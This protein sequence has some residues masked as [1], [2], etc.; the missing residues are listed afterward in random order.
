MDRDEPLTICESCQHALGQDDSGCAWDDKWLCRNCFASKFSAY[1]G[2]LALNPEES[3]RFGF[4]EALLRGIRS[5]L[6][7]NTL[8]AGMLFVLFLLLRFAF[9][10]AQ[11][12]AGKQFAAADLL[13]W[14]AFFGF[15]WAFTGIIVIP[16]VVGSSLTSRTRKIHI[17]DGQLVEST[18]FRTVKLSMAECVWYELPSGFEGARGLFWRRQLIGVYHRQNPQQT[19]VCGFTDRSRRLWSGYFARTLHSPV[20]GIRKMRVLIGCLRG[21]G[22]GGAA[23]VA[24]G[25][26]ISFATGDPQWI[27]ACAS[28]GFLDGIIW[29]FCDALFKTATAP[30]LETPYEINQAVMSVSIIGTAALL[31]FKIGLL[32]GIPGAIACAI[33]NGVVGIVAWLWFRPELRRLM[34]SSDVR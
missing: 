27:T 29:G 25:G 19:L 3:V 32:A 1:F 2:D 15:A 28:L 24:V 16:L 31:G 13:T 18:R 10:L 6:I 23:G 34:K 9:Q 8:F 26:I 21:L 7:A 22:I 20:P 5:A 33:G 12:G 17:G 11:L 14:L 30:K 4:G